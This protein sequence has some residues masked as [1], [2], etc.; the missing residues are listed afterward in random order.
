MS[1]DSSISHD[2]VEFDDLAD[3]SYMIETIVG[4]RPF[5][6]HYQKYHRLPCRKTLR[7]DNRGELALH[8][9][10]LAVYNHRSIW[11][12]LNNFCLEFAELNLGFAFHSEVWEKKESKKHQYKIEEMFQMKGITYI[13]TPR[14]NRR[15]GG[16]A[17]TCDDRN[18]YIKEIKVPNPNNLEVTFAT[19]RPKSTQSP[20]FT[21]ILCAVYSPPRSRKKSKLIDFISNTYNYLKSSKYPSAFFALGG[22][23]N[24]LKIDLLLNISPSFRQIVTQ[25]TRGNKILSVIVT[26]LWEY[27]QC[28]EILPP[29]KP[30]I[31]GCGKPSDHSA[32]YARVYLDRCTPKVKNYEVKSIQPFPESGILEF[33]QWIQT[34]SFNCVSSAD[35]S[36]EKVD[37]FEHLM[38]DKINTI[39]PS[40]NIRIYND[41]KE[42]MN[43]KLRKLRRQKSREYQKHKKSNKFLELQQK[44]LEMKETNC[45]EYV[46]KIE[47]LKNC[48][49]G[50]FYQKI[51]KVGSRL[52]EGGDTIFTLPAHL[53]LNLDDK[54]AAE[55][56]ARH[57]GAISQEFPPI[58]TECL[59]ERLKEKIFDPQIIKDIPTIEEYE[60]YEKFKKRK[61]KNSK[62]PGDIPKKLKKEFLAELAKPASSIFNCITRTGIYPRQWVTEFVSP[63][64]KVRPPES[65]DDLRNISLTSDLSKDYE[66]FLSEWLMPFI[67]K[68]IDPGQFGGLSGHSTAH[69]LITLYNFILKQ[70]DT[71]NIP[72]A[73]MVA[74]VD[75]SKAFNRINHAKVIVRLS[76]W[77][78]PGWLLR[79]LISYLTGRSMILRYKGVFSDRLFMPGG[80][81]QG[82]LLGVLLYLV[83]VSDIGMDLPQALPAIQG[84]VDLSSVQYPP[85]PAVSGQEVRLKFV[86]DLSLAESVRLDTQLHHDCSGYYLPA[87]ESILQRR[88]DD[89]SSAAEAHD[90]IINLDK[91][92]IMAFN[93][94][95]K[96]RFEPCFSLEG[97]QLEVVKE[98]KLLGL[99]VSND[100][101]WD[102]NTKDIVQRGQARL[103]FLRRLKLLGASRSTLID[104]YKLFCRSV[105]EYC[106][107]VWAG[108]IS[109]KNT[110]DIERIQKNAFYIIFGP[111]HTSYEDLMIE[112]EESSL[113]ERRDNLSL[114]FAQKC[115]KN[116]KFCTWFPPGVSTRGGSHFFETEVKTKRLRNSAI[117][118]M[119]RLLNQNK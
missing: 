64:P 61:L 44:Y 90:M 4:N 57:F 49:L 36:T 48:N 43:D 62:V 15:G 108:S 69:Y 81:P 46:M 110:Q 74:L 102:R 111:S 6:H 109:K 40:K 82:T 31:E 80:S 91:T 88:L 97:T 75:F 39:F 115:L 56:I 73:V 83:Y 114:K 95:R 50:Q 12:K 51:K 79:I 63:I 85:P 60:V 29:L 5:V 11:K 13:S 14:P 9:P 101:R 42:F 70:T 19:A 58:N 2:E 92:K 35:S 100:C 104:I 99:T 20:Q 65:E 118:Y 77:G 106:A 25:P 59:P 98:T 32:P 89:I 67:K 54:A 30:D 41:D 55:R 96:Y 117:P 21:I 38:T 86:D 17:I 112:I 84:T 107:P 28:P 34:E 68:R 37:A 22:D 26:D 3:Q 72:K 78:V 7:R 87:R 53:E 18:Y 119:T 45:K 94:T 10:N 24:D 76:D 71:S 27:Y 8:L 116:N 113:K 103:W 105:L 33:G 16:S 52:G 1:L 47:E 93:F 23:I 66:N